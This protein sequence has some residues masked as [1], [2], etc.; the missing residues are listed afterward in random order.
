MVQRVRS[1]NSM[2]LAGLPAELEL[3]DAMAADRLEGLAAAL[4]TYSSGRPTPCCPRGSTRHWRASVHE[5]L[6]EG[7]TRRCPRGCQHQE[8]PE[9][10]ALEALAADEALEGLPAEL[11]RL[12]ALEVPRFPTRRGTS[13]ILRWSCADTA[14]HPS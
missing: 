6:E 3:V 2:L 1:M 11:D 4:C 9:Q 10:E 5:D 12:D 7:A 13:D 14:R 8:A